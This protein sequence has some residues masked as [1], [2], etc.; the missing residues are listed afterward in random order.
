MADGQ[1]LAAGTYWV[2]LTGSPSRVGRSPDAK[3]TSRFLRAGKVVSARSPRS[4][5]NV[6]IG[7]IAKWR[8]NDGGVR[9]STEG[10]R[11][12]ARLAQLPGGNHYLINMPTAVGIG[13]AGKKWEQ[14]AKPLRLPGAA[15]CIAG[16]NFSTQ[17]PRYR[18]CSRPSTGPGWNSLDQ[19]VTMEGAG[20]CH[21]QAPRLEP[22]RRA[23]RT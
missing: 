4:S 20:P 15:S 3:P 1:P 16:L 17:S 6:E 7:S 8:S 21:G 18:R 10:E 2:R 12:S 11:L 22:A 9:V 14:I 5:P 13:G 19:S 23:P